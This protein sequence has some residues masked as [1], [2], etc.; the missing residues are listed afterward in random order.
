MKHKSMNLLQLQSEQLQ[1]LNFLMHF[2]YYTPLRPAVSVLTKA[3]RFYFIF[4][5]CSGEQKVVRL[6]LKFE[7][8]NKVINQSINK[9]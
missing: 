8:A 1:L 3:V 7:V 6:M 9:A 4:Y 5:I 2:S